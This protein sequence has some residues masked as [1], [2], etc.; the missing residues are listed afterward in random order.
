M[1]LHELVGQQGSTERLPD[2]I[3]AVTLSVL[4]L[5]SL[6][7]G[8]AVGAAT[9]GESPADPSQAAAP[10]Q[11]TT[12][13][14]TAPTG[15]ERSTVVSEI[16]TTP[17]DEWDDEVPEAIS[18]N[19]T[20]SGSIDSSD[21]VDRLSLE[22]RRGDV[23][24]L[25]LEKPS[26]T[27]IRLQVTSPRGRSD[28]ARG[29]DKTTLVTSQTIT[30]NGTAEIE[31]TGTESGDWTLTNVLYRGIDRYPNDPGEVV[32]IEENTS[33]TGRL[34]TADDLDRLRVEVGQGDVLN[35]LLEKPVGQDIAIYVQYPLGIAK[36]DSASGVDDRVLITSQTIVRN[37]TATIEIYGRGTGDWTLTN[38]RNR[39]VDRFVE[40]ERVTRDANTTVSGRV[41][42]TDD[43]DELAI[44]V[45]RGDILNLT[46]DKPVGQDVE[47]DV[48]P[49]NGAYD[50]ARGED[51]STLTVSR[52]IEENGT[53]EIDISGT[54]PGDWTLTNELKRGVDKYPN[55]EPARID[56]NTTVSGRLQTSEDRDVVGIEVNRGD[57]LNLTLE[58]PVDRNIALGVRYGD[59]ESVGGTDQGDGIST[60]TRTITEDRTVEVVVSGSDRGDWTLT[61]EVKRGVDRYAVNDRVQIP[62][63]T[64]VSGRVQ[65]TDDRDE[66]AVEVREG[67]ALNLTLEKPVGQD[68]RMRVVYSN[69]AVDVVSGVDD[70]ILSVSRTIAEDALV[71]IDIYGPGTGDW[72]LTSERRGD[73]PTTP[74]LDP[75]CDGCGRP[76]DV[77]GDGLYEDVNGD[78]SVNVI[79]VQALFANIDAPTVK[80]N[81]DA[82]DYNDDGTVN[83]VDVQALFANG[84]DV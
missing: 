11:P 54:E 69:D 23:L 55:Y 71:R 75:V 32:Q 33:V 36:T 52:L 7:A 51:E 61:N 76:T 5:T 57:V 53:F 38:E 10:T 39:G 67:D 28:S 80:N 60:A 20:V 14:E 41:Q 72:T 66:L 1:R 74:P 70:G 84:R 19:N 12:G 81:V 68:V 58:R 49:P 37:G 13:S 35:L 59:D 43:R 83:V 6:P 65:T 77:D 73:E 17:N 15:A 78:S 4:V 44:E 40:F 24:N 82:F 50:G 29:D 16:A 8:V 30:E 21:D 46:L 79:D 31:I 47:M 34:Q 25:S 26:G 64:T 9:S 56:A 63:N 48:T 3:L 2:R 27:D 18:P 62:S 22:V 45:H 42:T